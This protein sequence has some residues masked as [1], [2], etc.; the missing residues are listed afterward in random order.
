MKLR[1]HSNKPL[2][3]TYGHIRVKTVRKTEHAGGCTHMFYYSLG[4][5]PDQGEVNTWI[6][7]KH[8]NARAHTNTTNYANSIKWQPVEKHGTGENQIRLPPTHTY[9]E[10]KK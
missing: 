8:A 10:K 3:Y 2:F 4:L 6:K 9:T 7:H 5:T 1:F